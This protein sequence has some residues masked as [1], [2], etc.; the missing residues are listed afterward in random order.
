MARQYENCATGEPNRTMAGYENQ[1]E[2]NMMKM[3]GYTQSIPGITVFTPGTQLRAPQV[4]MLSGLGAVD[5]SG[6]VVGQPSGTGIGIL[7]TATN[8]ISA[9]PLPVLA[10]LAF[11]AFKK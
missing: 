10:L 4:P 3:S 5:A 2:G 11:L 1:T 6:N 9:N 7:D 8:F